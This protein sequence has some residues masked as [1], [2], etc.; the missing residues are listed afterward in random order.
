MIDPKTQI[1]IDLHKVLSVNHLT[2][3][4]FII[5]IERKGILFSAGQHIGVGPANSIYTREYSIYSGESDDY[6]EILV[7]EVVNGFISPL[8]KGTIKGD[9]LQVEEPRGYFT[10]PLNRT[11]NDHFLF[12][13]TGTGI[14]PFHSI[15]KSNPQLN[16]KLL[17]GISKVLDA[18]EPEFY[19][20]EKLVL[21]TSKEFSN[22]AYN[23]RVTKFMQTQSL[24]NT[25]HI[26][27]CGNVNMI[28]EVY[29]LLV[30]RKFPLDNIHSEVYF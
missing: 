30:K 5:K 15:I 3:S 7:K 17:H 1:K 21:C 25:S 23:G 20:I 9:Y 14:S 12:V 8:L 13:A 11:S 24:E 28:N 10:L 22:T 26:F 16:Y 2:D 4:L 27:L 29:D 18:C 19:N 6:L